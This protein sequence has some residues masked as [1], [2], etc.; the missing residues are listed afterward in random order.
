M[1]RLTLLLIL[2]FIQII[3]DKLFAEKKIYT[4]KRI[5]STAPVID[6]HF[7]DSIWKIVKWEGDFIQRIPYE[8]KA[9]SEKTAFKVL[10]DDNNIYFAV[11][12]YDDEPKKIVR[13]MSRRDD[14]EG[15]YLGISIDSYFDNLTAF[16][17]YVSAAGVKKD[18]VVSNDGDKE[19]DTWD[20]IWYVKTAVDDKGWTAEIKIPFTQLRFGKKENQIWGLQVTRNLSRKEEQSMWQLIPRDA[21]AWVSLYGELHGI[22]GIKPKRQ[23][24]IM[25]YTLGKLEKFKKE[26]GNPFANGSSK[27]ASAGLDGKIGITNDMTLDLTINPDFGQVEADPSVVNLTAFE[28]YFEEK[29]PFFIEGRNIMSFQ[30][31]PGDGDFSNNNL[32][33]SRRIGRKPHYYPDTDEDEYVK[34]PENTSIIGA[35]KLTGKTKK[36][37]S[38]AVLESLC[39]KEKAEIDHFGE[40]SKETVE[41]FTNY[42]LGRLQK[43]YNKG[44]TTIGAMFTATNRDIKNPDLNFLPQAAYTGGI[45]FSHFWKDKTYVFSVKTVFSRIK[46]DSTAIIHAQTSPLRYFQ[47]PDAGYVSLDSNRTTLS[48]QGGNIGFG[49]IGNG[50]FKYYANISWSS[51]GLELNDMGFQH[52]ADVIFGFL[53]AQYRIW[54]P[55][56]IFRRL[57]VNVNQW[58][59][60]DF[61]FTNTANGGNINFN[62]QFKNYW[63]F[64]TG[65]NIQGEDISNSELRGGP[66]LKSPGGWSN[67][68]NINTD[69]RKKLRF[70]FGVNNYWGYNSHSRM[71]DFWFGP[72]YQPNNAVKISVHPSIRFS[73]DKMQYVTTD[74]FGMEKRY[75][76]AN[77]NQKT[78]G[79]SIR[80]N[81]YITPNFSLQY[82]GQP[83]ISAG[84]YT[85]FKRITSPMAN[86]YSKRFHVFTNDEISYNSDDEQ[87]SVDENN[88]GT[89]DYCFDEPNF[90]FKQFRSNFVA[91]WEY[92]PGST[93]YFVW[94]QGRTGY[95]STDDFAFNSD[96]HD[97]FDVFPHNV[98]LIKVSYCIK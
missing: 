87:Y 72:E 52:N 48:G 75:I 39:S 51:P 61:G 59:F 2:L 35:F 88:D 6:G 38:V 62:T 74:D 1:K 86:E 9:P 7:N 89:I 14:L 68:F 42:F 40:R 60:W 34:I 73:N 79:I 29:R 10:Y 3:P 64:G 19:D 70:E 77:I 90:N 4:T 23:I 55:F 76:F 15:D 33:Y 8:G 16:T 36:G 94:S 17:F 13:R 53:W 92:L 69:M 58:G 37:L 21:A 65:I 12:A 46:G 32:F 83:F 30:L 91:R 67:W 85:E 25:P 84:K 54:E 18:E 66:S 98:F 20:P 28:T 11:R 97:L 5:N 22:K 57:N 95:S 41:P 45:D 93:L 96:M 50:H 56:S 26:E 31:T 27:N 78:I 82:Y 81:Y 43:D 44:N 71:K 49:K 24:E 47:R 63:H 80:L